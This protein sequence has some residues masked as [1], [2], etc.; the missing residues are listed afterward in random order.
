LVAKDSCEIFKLQ[1]QTSAILPP[2]QLQPLLLLLLLLL[3][4][5]LPLCRSAGR[6][7]AQLAKIAVTEASGVRC[8]D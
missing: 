2:P 5:Q 8:Q 4:S 7:H 3:Q 1:M 6:L